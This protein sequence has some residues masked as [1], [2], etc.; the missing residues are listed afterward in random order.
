[1]SD[2]RAPVTE[3]R[4]VMD[5][6]AGFPALSVELP[7]YAEAT[8][9]MA[10]AILDEA[11]KFAGEVLGPLNV[12]GDK[13]GCKLTADGVTT[14][15]GWK[16]LEATLHELTER[17]TGATHRLASGK[18]EELCFS[19]DGSLLAAA[20]GTRAHLWDARTGALIRAYAGKDSPEKPVHGVRLSP[21]GKALAAAFA[22]Q[23]MALDEA[24]LDYKG[25]TADRDRLVDFLKSIA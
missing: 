25:L 6:L 13:E 18:V 10:D 24:Q 17:G 19:G 15:T 16:E 20:V 11:A 8:P 12:V 14:P 23:L 21:D 22:E 7:A 4:F 1:M 5:E 9:D 2:Y 3:M